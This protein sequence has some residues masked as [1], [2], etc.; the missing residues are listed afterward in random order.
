MPAHT[1]EL[2]ATLAR[3]MAP[4]IDCPCCPAAAQLVEAG[5]LDFPVDEEQRRITHYRI[6]GLDFTAQPVW[7]DSA[8]NTAAIVSRWLTSIGSAYREALPQLL[9]AQ[10][11][12]D[13]AWSKDVA[14]RLAHVPK[15][16]LLIR[17]VRLFVARL[18]AA[19]HQRAGAWR[20]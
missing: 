19:P 9:S 16:D 6:S 12:A 17:N 11:A 5:H 2:L 1:P 8:G 18:S 14:Q 15:G 7:L 3:V 13:D 4:T 20:R 10:E